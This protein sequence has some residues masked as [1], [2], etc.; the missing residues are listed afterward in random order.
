MKFQM[1]RQGMESMYTLAWH[2]VTEGGRDP[3]FSS[4]EIVEPEET[5]ETEALI[6]EAELAVPSRQASLEGAWRARSER[7]RLL[8][9]RDAELLRLGYTG[10]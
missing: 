4:P 6:M 3:M 5:A 10:F 2:G 8:D 7:K 9:R 1:T